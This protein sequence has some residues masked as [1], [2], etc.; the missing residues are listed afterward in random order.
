MWDLP[1]PG[2]KPASPAL[3]G[4]FLTTV[5]PGKSREYFKFHVYVTFGVTGVFCPCSL[6]GLD[7]L[8][9]KACWL[10]LCRHPGFHAAQGLTAPDSLPLNLPASFSG[11][12]ISRWEFEMPHT[13]LRVQ[14]FFIS[15]LR[16]LPHLL[17]FLAPL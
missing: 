8:F 3:A 10:S 9:S 14:V 4:G 17:V 1:G 6:V 11:C 7:N 15:V 16:V 2:L 5:P 12:D 13:M